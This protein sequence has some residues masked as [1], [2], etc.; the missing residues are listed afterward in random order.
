MTTWFGGTFCVPSAER[1]KPS[2]MTIRVNA[3][4]IMRTAGTR[5]MAPSSNAMVSG[6]PLPLLAFWIA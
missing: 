1:V 3:V 2:T 4:P 6:E 5:L